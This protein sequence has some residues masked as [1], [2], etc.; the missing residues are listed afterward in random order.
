MQEVKYT[1]KSLGLLEDPNVVVRVEWDNCRKTVTEC[2]LRELPKVARR[3]KLTFNSVKR[4]EANGVEASV[5]PVL[6]ARTRRAAKAMS[7]ATGFD[8]TKGDGKSCGRQ[9]IASNLGWELVGMGIQPQELKLKW[10]V[11]SK[12]K[13]AYKASLDAPEPKSYP[14]IIRDA[15]ITVA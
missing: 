11:G 12:P 13:R 9:S 4:C 5:F 8:I 10:M 2:R 6:V 14:I 1:A 15:D 7:E 3:E